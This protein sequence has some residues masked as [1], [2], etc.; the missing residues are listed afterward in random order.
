MSLSL[1]AVAR[2]ARS[3]TAVVPDIL[4]ALDGDDGPFTP[5]RS[6]ILVVVDG[7]GRAN[8]S[9]R[10]AYARFLAD[11][12]G[13]RD[14]AVT[15]FPSTTATAL[16]T[17]LT[18]T[19]A[20]DHG[21]VGYRVRVPGTTDTPDQLKGW[22]THGLDPLTWQRS[23]PIFEREG[24]RGRPCFT[25]SRPEYATTG[26]TRAVQRGAEF[27]G[28]ASIAER[29][30][31][32]VAV[33]AATAGAL[34]Y[35]YIPEL[36]MVGHSR[37]WESDRWSAHLE[38]VDA[39][40]RVLHAEAGR[41]IGVVLTA[42]HGM[43]DVPRHRHVLLTEGDPL[44]DGVEV[45]AGEPRMLHLYGADAAGI[46][47]RWQATESARSWVMSRDDAI[48]AG[49]F[50][51]EVHPEV[52]ARIGDVLVAARAQIAYYDD[53]LADKGAQRM[54][55]QHG[56]LTDQERMVPLIRLGAFAG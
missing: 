51:E 15:V 27:L 35:L 39:A 21:I 30:R 56:S 31:V 9:A 26:F 19:E 16:T 36:D 48:R 45:I 23:T 49:L 8:L 33:A 52:A 42:D 24:G 22:E 37:G 1:P 25:V 17:L 44:L 4:A 12:M 18:G 38:E 28:A 40:M 3:L 10:A 43:V 20:G 50:G 7:L 32:A 29:V 41:D 34:V 2:S 55:G 6:A 5:A 14:A 53:R 46:R 47:E 54:V 11:R 13:K